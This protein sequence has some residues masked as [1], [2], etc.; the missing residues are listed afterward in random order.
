LVH[1]G[2]RNRLQVQ[3]IEKKHWETQNS[4][5]EIWEFIRRDQQQAS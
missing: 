5:C 3:L 2:G 4:I 1:V